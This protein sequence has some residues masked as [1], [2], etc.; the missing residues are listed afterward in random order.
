M[1][2]MKGQEKKSTDVSWPCAWR[3]LVREMVGQVWQA[4]KGKEGTQ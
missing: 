1:N 3:R 2:V 4:T